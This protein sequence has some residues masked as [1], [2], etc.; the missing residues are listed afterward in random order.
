MG[1]SSAERQA[2]MAS[3]TGKRRRLQRPVEI[4]VLAI[5]WGFCRHRSLCTTPALWHPLAGRNPLARR[6]AEMPGAACG[7]PSVSI[8]VVTYNRPDFLMQA[9]VQVASQDYPGP[10]E[11]VVVDDSPHHCQQLIDSFVDRLNIRY[12]HLAD[13]RY[14]IGEKRNLACGEAQTSGSDMICI[15]D[16][17]DI[18]TVDRVRQQVSRMLA[19]RAEC[20]SIQVAFVAYLPKVVPG[21]AGD[22]AQLRR[23]RGLPLP[24]ENSLCMRRAWVEK[25]PAFSNSSLGEGNVLF[26]GL[27]SWYSVAQPIPGDELP[28]LYIRTSASTAPDDALELYPVE[29]LLSPPLQLAGGTSASSARLDLGLLGLARAIRCRRF[30]ALEGLPGAAALQAT[31]VSLKAAMGCDLEAMRADR[32]N[33]KRLAP[34]YW[35]ALGGA[36]GPL[37]GVV[38][39]G[40]GPAGEAP[41]GSLL[42][43]LAAGRDWSPPLPVDPEG[44]EGSSETDADETTADQAL[45]MIQHVFENF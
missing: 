6:A 3:S 17:D 7:W 14:T 25:R 38:N 19:R 36:L 4:W 33:S 28:F 30:P 31:Q 9:L 10:I 1:A 37:G 22:Q 2:L 35:A 42:P 24:F 39:Q 21:L 32:W 8:Q 27:N 16:D 5:S 40:Y 12:R 45:D 23:C 34:G 13:R 15:W 26:D 11:V 20:S 43:H 41:E 18:F 44:E 29:G